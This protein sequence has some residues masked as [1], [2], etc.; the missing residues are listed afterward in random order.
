LNSD[1]AAGL[2]CEGTTCISARYPGA[3]CN[4]TDQPCTLSRCVNGTCQD[5]LKVGQACVSFD[6]CATSECVNGFCYDS[7]VCIAP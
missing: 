4:A 2:I 1:C 7:S 3:S 6:D 5:H